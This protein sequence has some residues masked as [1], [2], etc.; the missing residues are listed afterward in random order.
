MAT[1]RTFVCIELPPALQQ[2]LEELQRQLQPLG[3]GISWSQSLGIHLTLKFLGDVE[4]GRIAAIGEAVAAAVQGFAAFTI[5][6]AG[7]G[8]FPNLSRPRVLWV[9]I[10][11]K[12]GQ[13]MNL[14][15]RIEQELA[16]LGFP[17]E[18]RRFSPHLT[19][20]RV[21]DPEAAQAVAR[22]LQQHGFAPESFTPSGVMVMRS[23]L[24]STGAVYTPLRSIE[25]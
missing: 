24:K 1:I 8:G 22:A 12:S 20:G 5:T 15:L 6:V 25:L 4:A 17:R 19:L 3:G 18:E 9:G 7:T 10:Q 23:D 14:Q 13:L 16:A 21:K 11:E 2:R